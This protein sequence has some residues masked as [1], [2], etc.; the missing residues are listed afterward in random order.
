MMSDSSKCDTCSRADDCTKD[1]I[2]ETASRICTSAVLFAC[3][4]N[5]M[6]AHL[7]EINKLVSNEVGMEIN[8]MLMLDTSDLD[9]IFYHMAM[10][11]ISRAEIACAEVVESHGVH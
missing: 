3:T 4:K 8:R 1:V 2:A 7:E 11:V 5:K 6:L 10:L 9:E